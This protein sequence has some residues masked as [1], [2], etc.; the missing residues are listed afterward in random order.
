MLSGSPT[1]SPSAGQSSCA[2]PGRIVPPYC[3]DKHRSG[4]SELR[5]F[6]IGGKTNDED[7]RLVVAHGGHEGAGHIFVCAR[8]AVSEAFKD[9]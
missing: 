9:S 2:F 8:R 5:R 4:V 7:R 3:H 6:G 1:L